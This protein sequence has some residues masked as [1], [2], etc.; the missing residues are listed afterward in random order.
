MNMKS[1]RANMDTGEKSNL[2]TTKIQFDVTEVQRAECTEL[3]KDVCLSVPR[4]RREFNPAA[5]LLSR[6]WGGS[7][8]L[9]CSWGDH[10]EMGRTPTPT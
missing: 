7:S 3:F 5:H 8:S 1:E 2:Q 9:G 6:M 4:H 10:L